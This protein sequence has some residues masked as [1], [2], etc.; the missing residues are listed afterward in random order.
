MSGEELVD[1]ARQTGRAGRAAEFKSSV[2]VG[3]KTVGAGVI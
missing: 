1:R 3:D 2:L